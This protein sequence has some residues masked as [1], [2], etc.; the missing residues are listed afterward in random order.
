MGPVI[1]AA[2]V[3]LVALSLLRILETIAPY[4]LLRF[5]DRSEPT[6]EWQRLSAWILILGLSAFVAI[7]AM[8]MG[9]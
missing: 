7:A 9:R 8:L 6:P 2:A 3:A 5:L 4:G 1:F